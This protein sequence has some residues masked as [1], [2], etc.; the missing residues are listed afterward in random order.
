[1]IQKSTW[2]AL[3]AIGDKMDEYHQGEINAIQCLEEIKKILDD[4]GY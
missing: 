1:M 2:K 4:F 3:V